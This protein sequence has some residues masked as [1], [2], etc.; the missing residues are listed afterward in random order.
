MDQMYLLSTP[1]N[2]E[3]YHE[4]EKTVEHAITDRRGGGIY[5]IGRQS[6]MEDQPFHRVADIL[7]TTVR[8][9]V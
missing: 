5:T 2:S 3:I 4:K 1:D 6:S 8:V 9:C 7:E